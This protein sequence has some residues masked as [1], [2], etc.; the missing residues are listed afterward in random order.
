MNIE[1]EQM[2]PVELI[3]D[4]LKS[5]IGFGLTAYDAA[6]IELALRD[7][8]ALA[9]LDGAMGKA[10]EQHGISLFR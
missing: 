3:R 6:Y 8:L 1:V 4:G 7:R 5:A 9:T 2:R 10:A